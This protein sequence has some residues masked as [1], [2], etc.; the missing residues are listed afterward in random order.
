MNPDTQFLP[1][2]A[3]ETLRESVPPNM[4]NKF[5]N[6]SGDHHARVIGRR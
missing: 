4:V 6:V 2:M 5:L 1:T 3:C